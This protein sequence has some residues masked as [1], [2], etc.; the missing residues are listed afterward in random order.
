MLHKRFKLLKP[1]QNF[2]KRVMSN[3]RVDRLSDT[4]SH[5][6]YK[7]RAGHVTLC[8]TRIHSETRA[9]VRFKL[10]KNLVAAQCVIMY[11]M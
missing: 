7:S 9:H 8:D 1:R 2:D 11:A 3:A 4:A 6:T 10:E 5:V